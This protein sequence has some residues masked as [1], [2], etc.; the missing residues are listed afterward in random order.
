MCK[1]LTPDVYVKSIY[2]IDFDKLKKKGI[3]AIITDLDNTLVAYDQDYPCNQLQD[4][5]ASLQQHG[6][7][8]AIVSNNAPER[9]DKFAA[10]LDVPA[11]PHAVKPRRRAFRKA[12]EL[13]DVSPGQAAVVGDQVFTDVLGGNRLGL[14]TIL[15]V[16]VSKKDF[17]GTKITR[18][19]ELLVLRRLKLQ[20][21]TDSPDDP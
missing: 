16:P 3:T 13:L 20:G 2:H 18:K 8:V 1:K 6:F 21:L 4:W 5:F 11:F 12:L 9:V 15:V 10:A 17:F 7:S 14:F 19:L